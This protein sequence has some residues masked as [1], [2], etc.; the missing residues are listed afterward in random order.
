[1]DQQYENGERR[2]RRSSRQKGVVVNTAL[3]SDDFS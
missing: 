3:V 1:M 2:D